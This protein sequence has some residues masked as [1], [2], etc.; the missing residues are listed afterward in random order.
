MATT[1]IAVVGDIHHGQDTPTKRGSAALPLLSRFVAEVNAGTVDAVIELGDRISDESP[2]R[3]RVLQ[4]QVAEQLARLAVPRHH[5]SGNHDVACLSLAENATVLDRPTG[6]R[7]VVIGRIRCVFWQPDVGLSRARGLHLAPGDLDGLA[8]L[9]GDDDRPT[10]L[11]SH[12]P[13]SGHAQTGN[14]Y[15]ERN[16]GH[17]TYAEIASIRA[18]IAAAPCPVVALAGHVHWSTLTIVD[19]T[20]HLTLQSLTETFI[21]GEPAEA[22]AILEIDGDVLHWSVTGRELLSVTLPWARAKSHWRAP[23]PPFEAG[24]N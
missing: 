16:P 4:R 24:L 15:F 8:R 18:A 19:G 11:I 17:A 22:A 5:V 20:P 6:S 12:V 13:L 14:Y 2:D 9:L 21:S 1:R 3:D 10:L 7:A 23:L